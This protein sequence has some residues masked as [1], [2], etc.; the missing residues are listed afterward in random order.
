MALKKA[1]LKTDEDLLASKYSPESVIFEKF[2]PRKGAPTDQSGCTA[3]AA[4]VTN[5]NK[6]YVVSSWN[7][8]NFFFPHT[9]QANAGDSRSVLS[10][11]GEVKHLSFDHKPTNGCQYLHIYRFMPVLFSAA[12]RARIVKAGGFIENDR[13]NGNH[14]D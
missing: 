1:F 2:I 3:I 9:S 11:K 6:I 8:L 4:L 12:E 10:V 5:E 14:V 7:V 13:V